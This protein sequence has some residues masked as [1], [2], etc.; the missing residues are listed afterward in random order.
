MTSKNES[1][2]F[3]ELCIHCHS[4]GSMPRMLIVDIPSCRSGNI[5]WQIQVSVHVVV[6]NCSSR[7]ASSVHSLSEWFSKLWLPP[8]AWRD[9]HSLSECLSPQKVDSETSDMNS[10]AAACGGQ[11]E[12]HIERHDVR[13]W[14]VASA[15][16]SSIWSYCS[17][18]RFD[19]RRPQDTMSNE[20]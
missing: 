5:C 8:T 14:T 20:M 17:A 11:R 15:P 18:K 16:G 1:S 19:I 13:R 6:F 10:N 9:Q 2:T 3:G 12:R 7:I 4:E